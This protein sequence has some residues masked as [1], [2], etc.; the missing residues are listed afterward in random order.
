MTTHVKSLYHAC[1]ISSKR[2]NNIIQVVYVVG[3][4]FTTKHNIQFIL[5]CSDYILYRNIL[6]LLT[7]DIPAVDFH[8]LK[9][10]DIGQ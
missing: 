1:K 10:I 7:H 8:F 2:A 9:R 3:N 4:Q 6:K 5:I